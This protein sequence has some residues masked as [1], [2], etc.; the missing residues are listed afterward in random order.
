[1]Q[2]RKEISAIYILINKTKSIYRCITIIFVQSTHTL[3]LQDEDTRTRKKGKEI[4][5][6]RI[7]LNY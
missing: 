2:V 1:M 6:Q 7:E 5:C 4:I 3:L